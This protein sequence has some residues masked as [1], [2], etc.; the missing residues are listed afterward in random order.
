MSAGVF[1]Q[2]EYLALEAD[3]QKHILAR[4][5]I[6]FAL[7]KSIGL[8][9][10]LV[11]VGGCEFEFLRHI[12]TNLKGAL[13]GETQQWSINLLSAVG[14]LVIA[15]FHLRAVENPNAFPVKFIRRYVDFAIPFYGLGIGLI[16]GA[17]LWNDG[18]D[19]LASSADTQ[20][21]F[22]GGETQASGLFDQLVA[23]F[24]MVFVL[25]CS[26]L[27]LINIFTGHALLCRIAENNKNIRQRWLSAKQSAQAIATIRDCQSEYRALCHK[28]DALL[29]A[30][31]TQALETTVA[32]RIVACIH[33][34]LL[35]FEQWLA[36]RQFRSPNDDNRFRLR[37]D[38]QLDPKEVQKRIA[39]LKAVTPK[40]VIAAIRADKK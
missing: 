29:L 39:A 26:G 18:A 7:L 28:R 32:H 40:T 13:P 36:D 12:F 4:F 9:A 31:D 34:Q 15:G 37:E 30:I 23:H 1:T 38:L 2:K 5:G 6:G 21:L 16:F 11:V 17:V 24:G 10:V 22:S 33:A 25:G 3:A 20:T 19:A 8:V 14:A 27:A 35:P